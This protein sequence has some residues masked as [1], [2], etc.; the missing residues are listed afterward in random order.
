MAGLYAHAQGRGPRAYVTVMQGC[1]NY[2]AYCIVPY[3]R[4]REVSRPAAEVVAEVERLAEAGVV[5]VTLLGQNVN[6]FGQKPRGDAD[7]PELLRR[8]AA[9]EGIRR[10]RFTTSHPKDLSERLIAAFTEVPELMP[11]AHLPIQSGSDRILQ[12]MRRK[13]TREAYLDLVARLRAARPG[14]ALTSDLIVGFP[15][16]TEEDF[17]DTLRVMEQVVFDGVFSFKFSPRP[18]TVAA[19]LPD[20]VPEP[21]REERLARLLT[22]QQTHTLRRNREL[23]GSVREVLVEGESR[24]GKGQVMGRSPENKIV[25]FPGDPAWVGKEVPVRIREAALNSLVGEAAGPPR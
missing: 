15:G 5:E 4:G 21:L 11:H 8:V 23:E 18:G 1:D 24:A 12:G 22:L 3:V 6:S 25:N 9:V 13:Y 17:Q 20:P 7:F 16:E 19:K 2:C 14:I 10:I